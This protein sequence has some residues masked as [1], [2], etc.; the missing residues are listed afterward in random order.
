MSIE[1]NFGHKQATIR[2]TK[3]LRNAVFCLHLEP[4]QLNIYGNYQRFDQKAVKK[5]EIHISYQLGI[6]TRF[7]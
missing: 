5:R 7:P 1:S 6:D 4:R 2:D 3:L